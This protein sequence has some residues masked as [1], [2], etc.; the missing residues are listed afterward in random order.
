MPSCCD[1]G[2]VATPTAGMA[3]GTEMADCEREAGGN[4]RSW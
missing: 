2:D 1:R 3:V 4:E